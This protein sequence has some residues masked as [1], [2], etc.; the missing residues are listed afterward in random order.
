MRVECEIARFAFWAPLEA[1]VPAPE[2]RLALRPSARRG[3][4]AGQ[5]YPESNR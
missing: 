2:C 5:R 4:L 3:R 1:G